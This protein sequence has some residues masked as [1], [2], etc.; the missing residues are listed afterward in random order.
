V[1]AAHGFCEQTMG[2]PVEIVDGD[3]GTEDVKVEIPNGVVMK[4]VYMAKG[5]LDFDKVIVVSHF[6]G[7]MQGVYGA[8][9]KNVGIG[10]ASAHGK[11]AVHFISDHKVGVKTWKIDETAVAKL[12]AAPR[13]N[14]LDYVA[15]CCPNSAFSY[16][17]KTFTR[18]PDKCKIC[19]FCFGFMD[20]GVYDAQSMSKSLA[21]IVP[22]IADS[23]SGIINKIGKE[24]CIFATYAMDITPYCD[25]TNFHD[26]ALV[27]NIGVFASRDP[28][29]LDMACMEAEEDE[30]VTPGSMAD[31]SATRAP[32][33]ERF[34]N[35]SS[36]FHQG[37]WEQ[38]NAACHDGLG[39]TEYV[40]V[41]SKAAPDGDFMLPPYTVQK[42]FYAVNKETWKNISCDVGDYS[43][44]APR[45]PLE[46][47]RKK[48]QGKVG[49]ES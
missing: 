27:P 10:M 5:I 2:C 33:T 15:G 14:T 25:C 39:N 21:C 9:L 12:A 13:P 48:P 36:V 30:D 31:Q 34:S 3:Y 1:A 8:A 42:D 17:G 18:D 44:D 4:Y 11:E 32:R 16:D 26:R 20:S 49:E 28:V 23:A 7:H 47:L 35:V 22:A 19:G 45:V 38:I 6:K 24:N 37:Q 43:Y 46:D 41:Y 40:L 29:A